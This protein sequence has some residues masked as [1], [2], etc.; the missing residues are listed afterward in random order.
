MVSSDE[1]RETN[2][3]RSPFVLRL[4]RAPYVSAV[5]VIVIVIE[6][7]RDIE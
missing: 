6:R 7:R 5:I 4:Y 2:I 3:R 1:E